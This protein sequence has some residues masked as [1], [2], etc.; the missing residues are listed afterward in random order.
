MA[1]IVDLENSIKFQLDSPWH[2]PRFP[3][4]S[5]IESI[6]SHRIPIESKF[7]SNRSNRKQTIQTWVDRQCVGV[8]LLLA[9]HWNSVFLLNNR[10][11]WTNSKWLVIHVEACHRTESMEK[12]RM[13]KKTTQK[14]KRIDNNKRRKSSSS[15]RE[16]VY[17]PRPIKSSYNHYTNVEPMRNSTFSFPNGPTEQRMVFPIGRFVFYS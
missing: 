9:L 8:L 4:D 14:R 6:T 7:Q 12:Q 5:R 11:D 3:L 2:L 16:L 1:L 10:S 13:R 15:H 17:S